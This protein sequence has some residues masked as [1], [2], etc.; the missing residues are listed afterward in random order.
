METHGEDTKKTSKKAMDR[1][2]KAGLTEIR[3][4]QL[5]RESIKSRR[6]EAAGVGGGKSS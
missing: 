2:N 5:G 4:T 1:W 3:Y 6:V